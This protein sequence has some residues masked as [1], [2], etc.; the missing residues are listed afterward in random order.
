M[1]QQQQQQQ[2]EPTAVQAQGQQLR[3]AGLGSL[4]GA[5][6]AYE[7][8][9]SLCDSSAGDDL[10][11]LLHNWGAGLYAVSKHAQV[12]LLGRSKRMRRCSPVVGGQGDCCGRRAGLFTA[13]HAAY[14]LFLQRRL[15]H[16]PPP[17]THKRRIRGNAAR[18]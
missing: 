11:G 1:P 9:C 4:Q 7:R 14:R 17:P 18:C 16:P 3:Q 10:P 6:Q 8:S 5:L 15:P 2:P 13:A 12:G